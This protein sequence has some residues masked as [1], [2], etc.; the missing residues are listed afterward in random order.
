[1]WLPIIN[2]ALLQVPISGILSNLPIG[3]IESKSEI[4]TSNDYIPSRQIA[5][6]GT[7]ALGFSVDEIFASL[8][9][10]KGRA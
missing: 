5:C 7:D 1:M 8:I 9:L 6:A 4:L 3:A 2:F 10:Y